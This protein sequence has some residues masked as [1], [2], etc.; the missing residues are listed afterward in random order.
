MLNVVRSPRYSVA[1]LGSRPG[2]PA[3]PQPIDT[4]LDDE[5]RNSSRHH[6][7]LCVVGAPAARIAYGLESPELLAARHA[8]NYVNSLDVSRVFAAAHAEASSVD[9]GSVVG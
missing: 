1:S 7:A 2:R 5:V 9:A 8:P 6:C 4:I 3:T